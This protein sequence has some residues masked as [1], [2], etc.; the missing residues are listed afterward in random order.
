[1]TLTEFL[2]HL[3]AHAERPLSFLPPQFE[4]YGLPCAWPL[5]AGCV[6]SGPARGAADHLLHTGIEMRLSFP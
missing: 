2:T 6:R 4:A 3:R 1:M 5:P